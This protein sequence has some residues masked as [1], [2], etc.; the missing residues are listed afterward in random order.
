[1]I[2][3]TLS[4]KLVNWLREN[5]HKFEFD[6]NEKVLTDKTNTAG[7]SKN[8]G[9]NPD[10][11]V[12]QIIFV[13]NEEGRF[14]VTS[15]KYLDRDAYKLLINEIF[16]KV[17]LPNGQPAG[18]Y[19]ERWRFWTFPLEVYHDFM[20]TYQAA[21]IARL[22]VNPF[23]SQVARYLRPKP[24]DEAAITPNVPE[25][26]L[27]AL[28][29]FQREGVEEIIRKNGKAIL[30]DEMGL[31]KTIQ[32]LAVAAHYRKDWPLLIVSPSSVKFSW[33][34][35]LTQWI[36]E[37]VNKDNILVLYTGKD[38]EKIRNSLKVVIT[39]Y[40]MTTKIVEKNKHMTDVSMF[41]EDQ[42]R[43]SRFRMVILDESHYIK[44]AQAKRAQSTK[45]KT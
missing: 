20:K 13:K 33:L 3:K 41:S 18:S 44:S 11:I 4:G 15:E 21:K 39:S 29:P 22:T 28:Y 24:T 31:G 16:N 36:G 1:M 26:L 27:K 2:S 12:V 7:T 19:S 25:K 5:K 8:A 37:I 6:Q 34:I 42:I 9:T 17:R 14:G 40:E 30:A 35:E 45:C 23:P 43:R 38:V 32:A 10:Q